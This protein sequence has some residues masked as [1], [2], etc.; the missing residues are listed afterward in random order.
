[1]Q[2]SISSIARM[3]WFRLLPG[4]VVTLTKMLPMSSSGTRPVLVV[5]I[6]TTNNT[7]VAPIPTPT[8]HLR[9]KNHLTPPL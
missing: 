7:T 1:M 2:A 5:R 3:V 8:S 6:S 9:R 4:G